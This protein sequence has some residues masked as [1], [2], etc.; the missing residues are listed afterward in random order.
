MDDVVYWLVLALGTFI[1]LLPFFAFVSIRS[2]EKE[3]KKKERE[4]Y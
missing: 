2:D 3:K 4:C 1:V